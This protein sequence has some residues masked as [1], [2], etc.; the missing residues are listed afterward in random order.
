MPARLT[1]G[2]IPTGSLDRESVAATSGRGDSSYIFSAYEP[3][4][5]ARPGQTVR[6]YVRRGFE[7]DPGPAGVPI[8]GNNVVR[9][10]KS[11]AGSVV[12]AFLLV[13]G[14]LAS[15]PATGVVRAQPTVASGSAT[16]GVTGL[17]TL[18]FDPNA[19][20]QVPSNATITVTFTD[21]TDVA[22]TFSILDREGVVI[23]N[24]ASTTPDQLNA[25][26]T[27]YGYLAPELNVSSAG[28]QATETFA[29][30]APGWYEFVCQAPGHFQA[31][32]YGFIAF[33]EPLPSN[34]TVSTPATGPGTA[35]F[36]IVGTIVA[37]V[38]IALVLGFVVGQR[39]GGEHEMPPERLGYPEPLNP[40]GGSS[41][42]LSEA[43]PR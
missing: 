33:G 15:L 32:M 38:V 16:I 23:P 28:Q 11:V 3:P 42:P 31:G 17:G 24:P 40:T 25:L 43:P 18:A 2:R 27:T 22:H 10:R 12:V 6:P 7:S 21:Q 5:P 8:R 29:S 1:N 9:V 19:F 4:S 37:L 14:V 35:V 26:F 39:R 34:L 36:I 13:V 30:P 20:S 41:E